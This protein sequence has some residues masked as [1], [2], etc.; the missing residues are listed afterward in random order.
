[1]VDEVFND[2]EKRP[3]SILLNQSRS[4]KDQQI[5][6]SM[7]YICKQYFG[8]PAKSS[9]LLEFDEIAWKSLLARRLLLKDHPGSLFVKSMKK[10]SKIIVESELDQTT[11]NAE[12]KQMIHADNYFTRKNPGEIHDQ[13]R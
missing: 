1:M 8:W 4:Q 12:V 9:G 6:N 5:A 10:V 13:R 7:S 11:K 2:L 3:L